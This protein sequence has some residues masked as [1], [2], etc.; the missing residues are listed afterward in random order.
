[1]PTLNPLT[2]KHDKR[3]FLNSGFPSTSYPLGNATTLIP[4]PPAIVRQP[5]ACDA[6]EYTFVPEPAATDE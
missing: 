2:E 5:S 6:S 3:L 1:M 4:S